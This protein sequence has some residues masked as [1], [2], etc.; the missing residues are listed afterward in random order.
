MIDPP[1]PDP[2]GAVSPALDP[3]TVTPRVDPRGDPPRV[4]PPELIAFAE[5][6]EL[7]GLAPSTIAMRA[8]V[9][10]RFADWLGARALREASV[11]DLRAFVASRRP[12]LAAS[13]Q[14]TEINYLQAFYGALLE[15]G[16]IEDNP[17]LGLKSW[18]PSSP[19]RPLSLLG[20]RALLIE[21]RRT[22]EAGH[23]SPSPRPSPFREALALRDR[24]CLELLFATGLRASELC[25]A[26][27]VDLDLEQ[28]SLWVRRAKRGP[29]RR[30]PLPGPAV[31]ALREYVEEARGVLLGEREESGALFVT[32]EGKPLERGTL[33]AAVKRIAA[34][35]KV[36]AYPHVFRRTLA[37]ELARSGVSLP[38]IQKILGHAQLATTSDYVAV[39]VDDMRLALDELD[40][41]VLRGHAGACFDE[42]VQRRLFCGWQA[43]AA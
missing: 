14:V 26:Q 34:R 7:K 8:R 12:H 42:G 5:H 11:A 13:S 37:T 43:L 16:W 10:R 1:R 15:L 20:V 31:A 18:R 41:Q 2:A 4:D 40:R 33:Y 30:L 36:A 24:A 39:S 3:L 22:P 19:R 23:T 21:A 17:A 25:A 32:R 28:A 29:C 6:Q 35:A 38:V 27:V 9:L